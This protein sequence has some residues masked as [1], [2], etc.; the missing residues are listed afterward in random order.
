MA[1]SESSSDSG[2]ALAYAV[3]T[4]PDAA[5]SPAAAATAARA[6]SRPS[7]QAGPLPTNS[8]P[9]R[10]RSSGVMTRVGGQSS[11]T[12]RTSTS[13][14]TSRAG[15]QG[16]KQLQLQL[17]PQLQRSVMSESKVRKQV[18][19]PAVAMLRGSSLVK[20]NS[21]GM[22]MDQI[23]RLEER[24]EARRKS[25]MPSTALAAAAAGAAAHST[26]SSPPVNHVIPSIT[27]T[28]STT[29]MVIHPAADG[30]LPHATRSDVAISPVMAALRGNQLAKSNSMGMPQTRTSKAAPAAPAPKSI[31]DAGGGKDAADDDDDDF[32]GSGWSSGDS[33]R[34]PP[35]DGGASAGGLTSKAHTSSVEGG[36]WLGAKPA[37]KRHRRR[38][39]DN[40]NSAQADQAELEWSD[41]EAPEWSGIAEGLAAWVA[42][43]APVRVDE[44]GDH[45]LDDVFSSSEESSCEAELALSV[46]AAEKRVRFAIGK[47]RVHTYVSYA[48]AVTRATADDDDD[49][50]SALAIIGLASIA[51]EP[52]HVVPVQPKPR[53]APLLVDV[54]FGN[55][56]GSKLPRTGSESS[57]LDSSASSSCLDSSRGELD[58][59]AAAW[60]AIEEKQAARPGRDPTIIGV[61]PKVEG[62]W[63]RIRVSTAIQAFASAIES[64]ELVEAEGRTR[65]PAARGWFKRMVGPPRLASA[66]LEAQQHAVLV[67]GKVKLD[68]RFLLHIQILNSVYR[69]FVGG[70]IEPTRFGSHWELLGFQGRDPATDLR[71]VGMLGLVNLLA[72]AQEYPVVAR[73]A[74]EAA[75][76]PNHDY[77]MVLVGF[78]LSSACLRLLRGHKLNKTA[79]GL[80]SV[81]AAFHSMYA[82]SWAAFVSTWRSGRH[83]IVEY[84]AV[85][86]ALEAK[87]AKSV[88]KA[89]RELSAFEARKRN[90]AGGLVGGDDLE[91]TQFG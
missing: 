53:A 15:K 54:M 49:L 18:A 32:S 65:E 6:R 68:D 41:G 64:G 11:S 76:D 82:A 80:G 7:R 33:K 51:E 69:E 62:P 46:R 12:G 13:Q 50:R 79:N 34:M 86:R 47:P 84:D 71:G 1:G 22:P 39:F 29:S 25:S 38:S 3:M 73:A 85:M 45:G 48:K 90:D 70:A 87:L 36:Q 31:K 61:Q 56:R 66:Q 24:R 63:T 55:G 89:L 83:T 74:Y 78:R 60:R 16:G 5:V 17:Q 59:V 20:S 72:L 28:S 35:I 2:F 23:R 58:E 30:S 8:S 44:L 27:A 91:L 77:P 4:R 9:A 52:D 67:V 88:P 10:T 19:S 26:S 57:E 81:W 37:R 40:W 42:N 21:M 75:L 14:S 43:N